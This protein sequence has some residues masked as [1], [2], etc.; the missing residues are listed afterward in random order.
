[1]DERI[2]KVL[3]LLIPLI[4]V[5]IGWGCSELSKRFADKYQKKQTINKA[6]SLLLELYFQI[7]RIS[8]AVQQSQSFV[9]WYLAQFKNTAIGVD[10]KEKIREVLSSLIN[11]LISELAFYDIKRIDSDYEAILKEL[12][13][14]Y[15]VDAYRLKGRNEIKNLLMDID[16]Y[17]ESLKEKLPITYEE[18][19]LVSSKIKPIVKNQAIKKQLI[20]IREEVVSLSNEV[21][22][23]QRKEVNDTLNNIDQD[24]KL[25]EEHFEEIRRTIIAILQ[26]QM[27]N[28]IV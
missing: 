8:A 26:E 17:Y 5:I 25:Y 16:S 2:M 9:D 27:P 11:P 14:Y 18:Y 22:S 21:S 6:I 19:S 1:M 23:R 20:E 3:E 13:C 12:S 15:P 10:E 28:A 4:G 7:K 24:D